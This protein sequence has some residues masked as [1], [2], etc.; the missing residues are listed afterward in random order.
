MLF[1]TDLVVGHDYFLAFEPLGLC[2]QMAGDPLIKPLLDLGGQ[3]KNFDSH[4]EVLVHYLGTAEA[5]PWADALGLAS[6]GNIGDLDDR[7]QYLLV[8]NT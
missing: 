3:I 1:R 2:G 7:F 8:N 5:A 4:G 6:P